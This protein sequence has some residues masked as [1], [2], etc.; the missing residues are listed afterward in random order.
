M[1]FKASWALK[2][3]RKRQMLTMDR[4]GEWVLIGDYE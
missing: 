3:A 1:Y 4:V 2:R